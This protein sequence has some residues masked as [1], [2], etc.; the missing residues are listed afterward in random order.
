M[1]PHLLSAPAGLTDPDIDM[2]R[3]MYAAP[4]ISISGIDPRLNASRIAQRMGISRARVA[5]RLRAWEESGFLSRY[6]V[7]PNPHLFGLT[8]ATFNIRVRDR[9]AK[10][11]VLARLALVPGA[12]GGIEFL[13]DWIAATFVMPLDADPHRS[14]A[15]L[16]G[17]AD[18]EEVEES[19]PWA[20]P[21]SVR[22]L[23]PLERRI[24]R[25]LRKY[26]TDSLASVARHVGVS[27]RTITTRYGR[28]LDERAVWFVPVFDFRALAEPILNLNLV[29]RSAADREL[30][31]RALRGAYPQSIGFQRSR[32]G[33][34]LPETVGSF[35]A[36]APS[37]ARTE[38]VE[39]WVRTNPGIVTQ[40]T[41]TMKRV[42]SFPET[43]DRL[44]VDEVP[45]HRRRGSTGSRS[46][47]V[48]PG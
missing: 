27:T 47:G 48:P 10:E 11:P 45:D 4:G 44:L 31:E 17:L 22:T 6:D 8:G 39:A 5:A 34:A 41:L 40:E 33:P 38:E 42:F 16:R 30:F 14:A 20:P 25:V 2:L 9:L 46:A 12:V 19:I 35:F 23:S 37:A 32:F 13:G 15:L 36:V 28:L 43:F 3:V 18:V 29:F 21:T 26:P 1:A 24:V 7:W